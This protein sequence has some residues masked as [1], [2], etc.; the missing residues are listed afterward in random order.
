MQRARV[1]GGTTEV[2]SVALVQAKDYCAA[3]Q[4]EF[5]TVATQQQLDLGPGVAPPF[6]LDFRCLRRAAIQT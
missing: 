5:I 6:Q 4:K 1:L 2:E 3:Q